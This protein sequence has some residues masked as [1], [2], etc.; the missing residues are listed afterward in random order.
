MKTAINEVLSPKW[1]SALVVLA[2]TL[3][4]GVG[5]TADAPPNTTAPAVSAIAKLNVPN[6]LGSWYQVAWFPNSF[7]KQCV[8][9]TVAI[10]SQRPDG[11]VTVQNRC[12]RADGSIDD[13]TGF[14]RPAGATL[15]GDILSPAKLEVSFLPSWLRW[16]PAWG[17]Y[18]VIEMAADGRYAVVS[19]PT[20][21]YLWVLARAPKLSA[22]DE[23]GIRARLAELG[24]DLSRWQAHSHTPTTDLNNTPIKSTTP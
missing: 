18:W 9:D 10:Y 5:I 23:V 19:E 12:K 20:R 16:V 14:A 7:Q 4:C 8:S 15:N 21:E 22:E 1:P 11:N 6:Y 2:T 3:Y 13:A 17:S 24:Y